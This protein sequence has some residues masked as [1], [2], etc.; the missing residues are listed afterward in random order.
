MLHPD[1]THRLGSRVSSKE[2]I[3]FLDHVFAANALAEARG[4]SKTPVCV[5]GTHGIGKTETIE[6]LVRERGWR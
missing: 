6:A 4:R 1:R 5:W 3:A 2:L